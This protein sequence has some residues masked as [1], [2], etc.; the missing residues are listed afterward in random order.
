MEKLTSTL[1]HSQK[2]SQTEAN[3][4]NKEFKRT[5]ACKQTILHVGFT[6]IINNEILP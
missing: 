5:K 1:S 3:K 2:K 6:I 4:A